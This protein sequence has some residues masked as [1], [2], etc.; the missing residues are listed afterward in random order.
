MGA[1]RAR[2]I[3]PAAIGSPLP[4]N[5]AI[6]PLYTTPHFSANMVKR[7]VYT[8]RVQDNYTHMRTQNEGYLLMGP[9]GGGCG[10]QEGMGL[11]EGD[12]GLDAH[13][14]EGAGFQSG[15]GMGKHN[16]GGTVL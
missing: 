8:E 11:M 13:P 1:Y 12:G 16:D 10:L 14:G 5:L 4:E 7:R 6:C 3:T 2:L 9:G 15:F